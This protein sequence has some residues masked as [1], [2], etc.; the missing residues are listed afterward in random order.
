MTV[1]YIN[2]MVG[3]KLANGSYSPVHKGTATSQAS[4]LSIAYDDTVILNMN[5]LKAAV[6]HALQIAESSSLPKG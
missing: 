1:K 2:V 6:A 5:Q 3:A 4:D